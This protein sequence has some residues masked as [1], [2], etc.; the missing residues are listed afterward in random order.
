MSFQCYKVTFFSMLTNNE[1]IIQ[2]I[3][4]QME[5]KKSVIENIESKK[6][7]KEKKK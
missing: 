3:A 2:K 5:S 7:S 4:D 1:E 6:I